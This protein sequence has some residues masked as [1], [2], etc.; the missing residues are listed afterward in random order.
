MTSG[1]RAFSQGEGMTDPQERQ[2]GFPWILI[3]GGAAACCVIGT[4]CLLCPIGAL[5]AY[6]LS[7]STTSRPASASISPPVAAISNPDAWRQAGDSIAKV[8]VEEFADFQ[9]PYCAG[10]HRD[11]EPKLRA[12]YIQTGK[13]RFIF[14]NYPVLDGDNS[15][16]GESHLA[17][18]G[19]LCAGEQGRFWEYHDA[20]FENQSGE[21]S[22][23]FAEPHLLEFAI[24]LGLTG[25]AFDQCVKS[26]RYES[27]VD[28]DYQLGQARSVRGVPTFFINGAPFE[29]FDPTVFFDAIDQALTG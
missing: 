16:A 23:G 13:V 25:S 14:R 9:C 19:A 11:G 8:V 21:N 12:E 26:R 6:M 3:L 2:A 17:A 7:R 27:I 18:L 10:F 1:R 24:N 20:L 4:I 15:Q 28:A 29:G 22:G 5:G